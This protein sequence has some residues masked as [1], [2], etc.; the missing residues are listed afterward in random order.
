VRLVGPRPKRPRDNLGLFCFCISESAVRRRGRDVVEAKI[1]EMKVEDIPEV[2]RAGHQ[3]FHS[4]EL[5]TLYRTWDAHEVTTNFNQ[6]PELSLVAEA[7]NGKI[8]GFALGTTY[9]KESGGWRYGHVLW[10]GVS[11]KHQR[12]HVGGQLYQEMERRMH[13]DGVRMVFVDVARSNTGAIRFF[14]RLGYAKPQTEVWL[15]KVIQ[16]AR[17]GKGR[18]KVAARVGSPRRRRRA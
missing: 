18:A 9:E 7:G 2:Y 13:H 4:L 11:P 3:L 15:S 17:R 1:R 5:A 14:R 6:N 16:R 12:S 8:V 10:I